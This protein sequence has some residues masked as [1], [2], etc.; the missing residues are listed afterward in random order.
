MY[1]AARG[2]F[3]DVQVI[4]IRA[5][6]AIGESLGQAIFIGEVFAR[7]HMVFGLAVPQH[8]AAG[9]QR[10]CDPRLGADTMIAVVVVGS[11]SG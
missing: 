4:R 6:G 5:P 11:L 2:A 9:P 7:P 8:N 1:N 10:T 3:E